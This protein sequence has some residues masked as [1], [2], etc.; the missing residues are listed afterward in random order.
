MFGTE[1]VAA[2]V[3]RRGGDGRGREQCRTRNRAL[4]LKAAR[5]TVA[6]AS[7]GYWGEEIGPRGASSGTRRYGLLVR[8]ASVGAEETV[9]LQQ[10]G[11]RD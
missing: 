6:G 10:R 1:G 2:V 3:V 9:V 8:D 11:M 7:A 5:M 4:L